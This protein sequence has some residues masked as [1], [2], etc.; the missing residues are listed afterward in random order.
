M[1]SK[2]V[3]ARDLQRGSGLR[4][5]SF[6]SRS[7]DIEPTRLATQMGEYLAA[8]KNNDGWRPQCVRMGALSFVSRSL[9]IEPTRL[10]TQMG[11]Y[12]AAGKYS[13][14]WA[15]TTDLGV[16]NATL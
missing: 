2:I 5:L 8:G 14:G 13:D 4:A 7:L 1:R 10:A 16:M 15:R 9:D 6:V 11:E 3:F 12:L